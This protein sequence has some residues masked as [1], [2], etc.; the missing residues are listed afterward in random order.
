MTS[1]GRDIKNKKEILALLEALHLPTALS[2]IHCPGHQKG[3]SPV[4][5]GNRRADWAAREAALAMES[6]SHLLQ[7][8]VVPVTNEASEK[9]SPSWDYE[10][11][12]IKAMKRLGATRVHDGLWTYQG[13][14][15]LPCL[16]TRYLINSLHKLTHLSPRKMRELLAREEN[17]RHLLGIEELLKQVTEQCDA[18]ARVN[19]TRLKLPMGT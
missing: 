14:T 15:V 2:I 9:T 18:C 8:A 10:I 13:K 1:E 7:A 19:A 11:E 4:A 17:T 12:D 3:D 5:R 6:S 16:M